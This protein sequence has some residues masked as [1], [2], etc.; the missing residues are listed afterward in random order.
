MSDL[1]AMGGYGAFVWSAFGLTLA[2]MV[3]CVWQARTSQARTHRTLRSR[4]EAM[5][6][7]K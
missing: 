3:T 1:F 5:E 7:S 2:V 6:S 4:L